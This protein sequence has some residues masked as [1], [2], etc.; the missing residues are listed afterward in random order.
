MGCSVNQNKLVLTQSDL[1][2]LNEKQMLDQMINQTVEKYKENS[3]QIA[4]FTV[5]SVT[6]LAIVESQTNELESQKFLQRTYRNLTGK[7][8]KLKDSISYSQRNAQY[9]AQQT[10]AKLAEQNLLTFDILTAVNS[11]LN[12]YMISNSLEINEMYSMLLQ[13]IRE[14]RGNVLK[15]EHQLSHLNQRVELLK[16]AQTAE[17]ATFNGTP[18][19]ELDT[20]SKAVCLTCDFYTI[21]RG[22]WDTTDLLLI[23]SVLKDLGDNPNHN[24][25]FDLVLERFINDTPFRNAI[26]EVIRFDHVQELSEIEIPMIYSLYKAY[27][28][29]GNEKYVVRTILN[30]L[31]SSGIEK[32]ES[33]LTKELTLNYISEHGQRD[34][35][36]NQPIFEL[37]NEL[38]IELKIVNNF[39]FPEEEF[40]LAPIDSETQLLGLKEDELYEVVILDYEMD[41]LELIMLLTEILNIEIRE[42]NSLLDE[43][44]LIYRIATNLPKNEAEKIV[45]VLKEQG[46]S[47]VMNNISEP[48]KIV[49]ID[50]GK[51]RDEHD[52]TNIEDFEFDFLSAGTSNYV[53][54]ECGATITPYSLIGSLSDDNGI[55]SSV[56]IFVANVH[57]KVIKI[58][59]E[60]ELLDIS[61]ETAPL[62]PLFCLK[63]NTEIPVVLDSISVFTNIVNVNLDST[64]YVEVKLIPLEVKNV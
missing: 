15:A 55:L 39:I 38:L 52:F 26:Q 34:L 47:L 3:A 2:P 20:A 10:L 41:K 31:I 7:N 13:F 56:E 25:G 35:T 16:W 21:A 33:Q 5:D 50:I 22:V 4:R 64:D 49:Y 46:I 24:I 27:Y 18:Y 62:V 14:T 45:A 12:A 60:I 28:F 57:G 17:Y 42:A 29:V 9:A 63:P 48:L 11:K 23:K 1:V 32:S 54:M 51:I 37:I 36:L 58:F 6:S 61:E 43:D 44:Q 53:E 59:N 19:V 40:L 8:N 30:N